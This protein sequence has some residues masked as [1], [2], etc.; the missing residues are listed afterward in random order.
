MSVSNV[1]PSGD[2]PAVSRQ[3]EPPAAA[4]VKAS[5][6]S[7][8]LMPLLPLVALGVAIF[9]T[10]ML[11]G[12]IEGLYR[13]R[14]GIAQLWATVS[15]MAVFALGV[16]VLW[17]AWSSR[18]TLVSID[19]KVLAVQ[20]MRGRVE[21]PLDQVSLITVVR[22][23]RFDKMLIVEVDGTKHHPILEPAGTTWPE[24]VREF[25]RIHALCRT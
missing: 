25:A 15:G 17:G 1:D 4:I 10:L 16:A 13:Y 21:V 23:G 19:D 22:S 6:R 20:S 2:L 7:L 5:K 9:G 18:G 11:T 12:R 24:V 3:H 8:F 14:S